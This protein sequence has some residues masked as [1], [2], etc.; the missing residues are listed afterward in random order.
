[1]PRK[2]VQVGPGMR[3]SF[4]F[5]DPLETGSADSHE[6]VRP[7]HENGAP[8]APEA[9]QDNDKVFVALRHARR[10]HEVLAAL[11]LSSDRSLSYVV[12]KLAARQQGAALGEDDTIGIPHEI[13]KKRGRPG[14]DVE[15]TINQIVE[16][17]TAD[18][19]FVA[20]TVG[21]YVDQAYWLK[22]ADLAL[23]ERT[24][25]ASGL[26]PGQVVDVLVLLQLRDVVQRLS[27]SQP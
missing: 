19:S 26:S 23:L 27:V 2:P 22:Q 11:A 21:E 18:G 6:A 10:M 3:V 17:R 16:Q 12:G 25:Q 14:P 4:P 9:R 1:M 20:A 13:L 8:L 5:V 7:T 15:V 24:A